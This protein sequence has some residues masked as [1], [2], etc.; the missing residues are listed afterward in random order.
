M[1]HTYHKIKE[2]FVQTH[3][4]NG[5][6][7]LQVANLYNFPNST[8]LNQTIGIIEL[9]GG[10]VLNDITTYLTNLG[11]DFTPNITAIEI[12]GATN[13]P[14][15]TNSSFEVMLDI[16]II[17]ALVPQAT[18]RVY[19]APN[20]ING[21]YNG[22]NQAIVDNCGI[23]SISWGGPENSWNNSDLT[24][25]NNLFKHATDLN[26]TIFCASGDNGSGDGESGV[27]VD[28]PS[29]SPYVVACGGT[30]LQS[31]GTETVWDNNPTS[32][33][34]GGGISSFFA[35][36]SYQNSVSYL[37][38]QTHRCTPDISGCADPNTGYIIYINTQNYLV[39]GT[40]AVAPLFSALIARMNTI[41]S[42]TVGFLQP[43]LYSA[44]NNI[45][46]DI[47]SGN[48]G[49]Y[50]AQIGFDLCTGW[51]S[52][53]SN[54]I[55]YFATTPSVP[56]PVSSFT[57]NVSSGVIPLIVQFTN[58]STNSPTSYLWSF[59]DGS[60]TSTLQNPSHTF[61]SI[62]TFTVTLTTTN[63][64][65]SNSITHTVTT[66]GVVK[67]PVSNFN[68][69]S[70]NFRDTSTN[71]PTSWNWNFGDG[72]SSTLQNPTHIYSKAGNYTVKLVATNSAGSTT[73]Q[74]IITLR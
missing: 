54:F 29:S 6:T 59:G 48:N 35:K 67:K 17:V 53:S 71:V 21:F 39:G 40:S 74:N 31:D 14:S 63:N 62:G 43:R 9:G 51:G 13:N 3:T 73:S 56:V 24:N 68:T 16:E 57:M 30:T 22:I 8:G 25:Y 49:A 65:G 15:D 32:S 61:T 50:T 11:I 72:G 42:A 7:P 28:F 70:V 12:D 5:Y 64:S 36:P 26:I 27:N 19:F 38:S 34:T 20:T 47:T 37:S 46:K 23:I 10:Y 41:Y 52:P 2:N 58:T 55:T 33:A 45:C 1:F 44:P 60:S 18:I 69:L 4:S 66:T